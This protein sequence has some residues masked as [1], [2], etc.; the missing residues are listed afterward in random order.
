MLQEQYSRTALLLGEEGVL[1]LRRAAVAVFGIGGVGSFAA[2]ALARAGVGRLLLVDPDAVS[3]SNINRQLIALHSTVGRNK[4]E[5]MKT[6]I[7]DIDPATNVTALPVFYDASTAGEI[8]LSE[9]DYVVDA[10]DTVSSKLLLIER[11]TAAGV[12]VISSMGAGNKL[13]PAAFEAADIYETS[14]CPLARVMRR[15]LKK[16]G[17]TS[18]RVVYSRE[19][20]LKPVISSEELFPGKRQI[21]GSI[22]FVPSAAG[23]I[24]AGEVVRT[25]AKME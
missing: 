6:R 3:V 5:V 7:A 9:F 10:I 14:V 15:E 23:L 18:L 20:A 13:D 17:I 11:A 25:L 21:P 16:R 19:E 4:A 1:R 22:S 24:L 8:D 12:P 2:E